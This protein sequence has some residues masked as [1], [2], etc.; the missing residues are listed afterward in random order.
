M[1]YRTINFVLTDEESDLAAFNAAI[2]LAEH[3]NGHLDVFCLGYDP[4]RYDMVPMG[5]APALSLMATGDA[6][7]AADRLAKWAEDRLKNVTFASSVRPLVINS[8]GLESTIARVVRFA[9]L[10]VV[11]QPYGNSATQL[12]VSVLEAALFGTSAPVLVVPKDAENFCTFENPLVMWNES[13]ES[14]GA[15]RNALPALENADRT[16]IVMVDP[17]SHSPDRSDPGGAVTLML[18]RHGITAEVSILS[19]TLPTVADVINRYVNDHENDLIV[20][21]AYG[22]SR[23]REALIGGAT[24]D[25]LEKS[26][27]PIM[28]SH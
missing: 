12:N 28:M 10:V 20:M 27:V 21:G 16:Q 25:M 18:S 23:F 9:D 14:L 4:V 15:I 6:Q 26:E 3:S 2:A 22:H 5:S 19:K 1:I 17:P 13:P 8:V 11:P 24:R 7:I